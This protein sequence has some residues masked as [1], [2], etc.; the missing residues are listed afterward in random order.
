MRKCVLLHIDCK[1]GQPGLRHCFIVREEVVR[2][3]ENIRDP[4]EHVNEEPR[5]DFNDVAM[6]AVAMGGFMFVVFAVAVIVKFI[7]T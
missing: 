6:G 5:H 4:R 2:K 3:M 7:I 1:D